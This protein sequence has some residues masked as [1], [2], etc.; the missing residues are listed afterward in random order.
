MSRSVIMPLSLSSSPQIG[1]EPTSSSASLAAASATVSLSPMHSQPSVISSFAVSAISVLLS[2]SGLAS[3]PHPSRVGRRASALASPHG[4]KREIAAPPT[5]PGTR[6]PG[7]EGRVLR[8]ARGLL[9]A[10]V[11]LARAGL[12]AR[13]LAVRPRPRAR[14][15]RTLRADPVRPDPPRGAMAAVRGDADARRAG[16]KRDRDRADRAPG[17]GGGSRLRAG[18]IGLIPDGY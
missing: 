3:L 1:T 5:G 9:G 7:G 2:D 4:G 13:D 8:R 14:L 17:L 6:L 15:P 16:R 18:R 11:L 10:A 12:R